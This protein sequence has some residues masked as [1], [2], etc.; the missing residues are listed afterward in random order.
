[1]G[2]ENLPAANRVELAY[3]E[4]E[5]LIKWRNVSKKRF[6]RTRVVIDDCWFATFVGP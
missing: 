5:G 4:R 6:K 1:M 3:K 2:N